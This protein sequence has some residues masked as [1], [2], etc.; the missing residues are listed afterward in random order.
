MDADTFTVSCADSANN[1]GA[2]FARCD[3]ATTTGRLNFAPGE[4]QKTI[5]VPIINDGHDER[6]ENFQLALS[7]PAGVVALGTTPATIINIQDNDEGGAPNPVITSPPFFVRQQ[8]LD[9]LSREPDAGGFDAWLG[10]LNNCPNIFNPPNVPSGCDRIFVS[11]EGFF[12]SLEFQLKGFYVFRFYKVT[13][14][15]LPEYAEIISDMSFVA[16]QTAGEVY[17]RKAQLPTLITQRQEFKTAYDGMT[18]A[19]YVSTLMGRYN[20]QQVTTPD[21]A[22]PDG[23]VKATL[24]NVDLTNRLD[25][26]T[27]TRAQVLRAVADSDAVGAREFDNAFVAMQYYG[28]LR[29]KPDPAGFDDWLSV[30]QSGDV[31]TMVNGFLNSTEYK[32]RFGQP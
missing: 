26:N 9:F 21:P 18:N 5:T 23:S 7:N 6:T 12:R 15:R 13:F 30:L 28:Y 31:R 27:L 24:T 2:A 1:N 11:G 10:V 14:N 16:G 19:Q 8:Y 20:L 25:A 17:E 29:R 4:A 32:L 3:F 22:N